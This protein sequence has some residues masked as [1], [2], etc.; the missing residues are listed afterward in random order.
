[1]QDSYNSNSS[2]EMKKSINLDTGSE[3]DGAPSPSVLVLD[4]DL[5]DGKRGEIRIDVGSDPHVS[6]M[7]RYFC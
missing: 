3:V 4:I 1:V 7:N 2:V 6:C 5:G